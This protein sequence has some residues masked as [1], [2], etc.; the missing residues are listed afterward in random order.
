[1]NKILHKLEEVKFLD[2]YKKEANP[3]V[4]VRFLAMQHKKEGKNFVEIA[5][6]LKI[7]RHAVMDWHNWFL[8]EGVDGLYDEQR[9]GRRPKLARKDEKKFLD[10]LE[11]I[12][13]EKGGGRITGDDIRIMLKEKFNAEYI[14]NGVYELLK[15]LNIVWITGRSIHPKADKEAQEEFKKKSSRFN[16]RMSATRCA[17]K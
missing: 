7:S 9:S 2:L 14:T 12:Q 3:R 1:M 6:I 17:T 8:E 11:K 5:D 13:N 15:R 10:E 16:K 4:R